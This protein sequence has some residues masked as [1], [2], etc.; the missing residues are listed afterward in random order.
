MISE[1][2]KRMRELKNLTQEFMAEKLNMSQSGYSKI[3]S[4]QSTVS[5]S[6]LSEIAELLDLSPEDLIS[7]DSQKFSNS[8][9]N[10]KGSNNGSVVVDMNTAELKALYE[11]KI[12][13][14]EKL[15]R[16]AEEE[17]HRIKD[18]FGEV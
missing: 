9:N 14:L 10:V 1:K 16:K 5:F 7:F 17:L 2:I 11:S 8:F 3:E 12:A 4:G 13:L 18:K 6:K 15:L